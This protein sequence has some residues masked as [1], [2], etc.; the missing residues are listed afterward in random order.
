MTTVG[1]GFEVVTGATVDPYG[2]RVEQVYQDDPAVWQAAIGRELWFQFGLYV[3]GGPN[4]LDD[5]GKRYFE[6]QLTLAGI[7]PGVRLRRVLDVGF[8]W[9][10]S[11]AHLAHRHPLCP[12][13]DGINLSEPQVRYA[14]D[15]IATT[16]FAERVHLYLGNAKDIDL[17]PD[18]EPTYDLVILRGTIAHLTPST[19]E[20][21]LRGI[22]ARTGPGAQMVV[23][24]TLCTAPVE[25]NRS[26]IPVQADR[27]ACRHHRTISEL[28][29]LLERHSF[30]VLDLRE[31]PGVNDATRWLDAVRTNIEQEVV[32]PPPRPIAELRDVADNLSMAL[33]TGLAGVYSLIARRLLVRPVPVAAPR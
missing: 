28:A 17:I 23:S 15:R 7:A 20:A 1:D 13:I 6:Q 5:V 16:P 31:L 25:R 18:P 21:T 33:H 24:E 27:L 10:T 4:S 3:A 8:G 32:D 22:A 2:I 19:L 12:R 30:A 11:L 9:G 14:A 26:A 29:R